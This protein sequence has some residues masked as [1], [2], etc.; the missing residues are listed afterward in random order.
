MKKYTTI[1]VL[2]IL[3]LVSCKK[4]KIKLIHYQVGVITTV[5]KKDKKY[6]VFY[7]PGKFYRGEESNEYNN[8]T[9]VSYPAKNAP[10][11]YSVGDSVKM[12]SD[13]NVWGQSRSYS[14]IVGKWPN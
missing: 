7:V 9:V 12:V 2:A 6:K 13:P 4:E 1:A 10:T 3:T 14:Q 11:D 5:E 8:Q